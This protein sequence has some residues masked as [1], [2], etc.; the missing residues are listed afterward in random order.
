MARVELAPFIKSISGKV[1]NLEF[2]TL[3][4]GKVVVH[5]RR[6]REVTERREMTRKEIGNKAG[7]ESVKS[8]LCRTKGGKPCNASE[9]TK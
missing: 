7:K 1:G 4:S 3:R 6:M 9:R 8:R 5:S 2:R